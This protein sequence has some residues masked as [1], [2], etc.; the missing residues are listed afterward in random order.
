MTAKVALRRLSSVEIDPGA[1]HQREFH[2]VALRRQFAFPL[3]ET[4]GRLLAVYSP[5]TGEAICEDTT[6]TLYDARTAPRSEY[7]LYPSTRLFLEKAS[8]GDL[9]FI[10]RSGQSDDLCIVVAER[11]GALEHDLLSR[12]FSGEPPALDRFRFPNRADW[13][14]APETTRLGSVRMLAQ[15]LGYS[16]P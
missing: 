4:R 11:G 14:G 10:S 7:H 16:L 15:K 3:G 2:A 8:A 1:S 13:T 5:M 6:Y 12:C 9:L